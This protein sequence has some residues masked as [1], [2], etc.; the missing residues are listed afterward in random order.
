[1]QQE[2]TRWC[3]IACGSVKLQRSEA[4]FACGWPAPDNPGW[5]L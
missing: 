1:M 5:R 4:A 3:A 2:V